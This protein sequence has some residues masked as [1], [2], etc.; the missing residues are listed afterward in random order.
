[1]NF[2]SKPVDLPDLFGYKNA[3]LIPI[4]HLSF[5]FSQGG[6]ASI[7]FPPPWLPV[8]VNLT[9]LDIWAKQTKHT[10]LSNLIFSQIF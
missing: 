3:Q 4:N 1:M 2:E 8:T 9:A 6:K 10:Y 5:S 7:S